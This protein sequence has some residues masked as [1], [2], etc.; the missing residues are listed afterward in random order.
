MGNLYKKYFRQ[1]YI[2]SN[3]QYYKQCNY[4]RKKY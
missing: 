3:L 1:K 4:N 2:K